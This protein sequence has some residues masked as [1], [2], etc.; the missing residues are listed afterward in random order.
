MRNDLEQ[1]IG[2]RQGSLYC[3][4][5]GFLVLVPHGADGNRQG[6]V[7]QPAHQRVDFR[8]QRRLREFLGKAPELA[9]ASDGRMIVEK[10]AM[11]VA[12]LATLER[13]WDHLSALGVVAEAG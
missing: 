2:C 12:A 8:L 9:P 10:H 7:V 3:C 1:E 4:E 6:A 13:D 11:R 5:V